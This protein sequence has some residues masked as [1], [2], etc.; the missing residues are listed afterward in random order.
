MNAITTSIKDEVEGEMLGKVVSVGVMR[1]VVVDTERVVVV[2]LSVEAGRR[3]SVALPRNPHASDVV[4]GIEVK[5]IV[6]VIVNE[7][8]GVG[9]EG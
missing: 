8:E 5:G 3:A 7:I 6:G 9:V 2:E 4:F 1:G